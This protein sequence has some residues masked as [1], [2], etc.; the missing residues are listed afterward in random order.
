MTTPLTM[1]TLRYF[2]A[3]AAW[4]FTFGKESVLSLTMCP[5]DGEPMFY[6][7]RKEAVTAAK[8]KGLIVARNGTVAVESEGL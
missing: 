1:L 8:R 3:N 5:L 7:S 6:D 4:A 2:P